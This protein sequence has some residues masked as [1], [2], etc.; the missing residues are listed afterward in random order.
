MSSSISSI[1]GAADEVLIDEEFVMVLPKGLRAHVP[2]KRKMRRPSVDSEPN[3][4]CDG[5]EDLATEMSASAKVLQQHIR[6]F[7]TKRAA[8]A[9][10]EKEKEMEQGIK[11]VFDLCDRDRD[12][13]IERMDLVEVL[14]VFHED[15]HSEVFSD[16]EPPARVNPNPDTVLLFWRNRQSLGRHQ[17]QGRQPD[18]NRRKG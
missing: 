4:V 3:D 1:E 9:I 2:H 14:S 11:P 13:F 8:N 7:A 12:G 5:L 17:S 18:D 6:M 16:G 10:V 15:G